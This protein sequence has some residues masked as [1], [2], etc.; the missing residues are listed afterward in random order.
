[1]ASKDEELVQSQTGPDSEA[2][3]HVA[4]AH[5]LLQILRDKV[6]AGKHYELEE[7]LIKLEQALS[8]LNIKTGGML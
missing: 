2:A 3:E 8:V 6:G 4:N 1:M 5:D 7:A